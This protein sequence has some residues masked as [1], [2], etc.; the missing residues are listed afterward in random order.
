M[1]S[2]PSSRSERASSARVA[3]SS[4]V[5]SALVG[6]FAKRRARAR[7]LR[8]GTPGTARSRRRR[9]SPASRTSAAARGR[10]R[11]TVGRSRQPPRTR[12]N[13]VRPTGR[14]PA[15]CLGR[16]EPE[17]GRCVS[18]GGGAA[19]TNGRHL[20]ASRRLV[21][22]GARA[23]QSRAPSRS[24]WHLDPAVLADELARRRQR[25]HLRPARPEPRVR[26]RVRRHVDRRRAATPRG[27]RPRGREA[28]SP[29]PPSRPF[30]AR[31]GSGRRRRARSV[32]RGRRG[33]ARVRCGCW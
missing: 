16:V 14:S 6:A 21:I 4:S 22:G 2:P 8:A 24:R 30:P 3:N 33:A 17:R 25:Q 32:A 15:D 7:A 12:R 23:P 5:N 19:R 13:E 11:G 20:R 31:R 26:R 27:T 9:R 28:P 29:R 10:R 18:R 1:R